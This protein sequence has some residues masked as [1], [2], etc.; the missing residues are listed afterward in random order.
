MAIKL[1]A[2]EDIEDLISELFLEEFVAFLQAQTHVLDVKLH[3]YIA[4]IEGN[5]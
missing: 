1:A 4:G 2:Q 3:V 5:G